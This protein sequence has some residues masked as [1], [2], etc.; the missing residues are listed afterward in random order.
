MNELKVDKRSWNIFVKW[1]S[2]YELIN[3][4]LIFYYNFDKFYF[5]K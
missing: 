4:T 3:N 1:Y 5:I 2:P